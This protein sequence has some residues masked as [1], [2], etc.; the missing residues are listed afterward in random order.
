MLLAGKKLMPGTHLRQHGFVYSSCR[1]F[2]KNK[3]TIQKFK[4]TGYSQYIY[5][6]ELNK[7]GFQHDMA[8]GDLNI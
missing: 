8:Y 2:T 7:A 4:E 6:I 5:E 1:P 3:E